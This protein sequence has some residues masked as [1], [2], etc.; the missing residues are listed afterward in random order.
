MAEE[1]TK[2]KEKKPEEDLKVLLAKLI[3]EIKAD[4]KTTESLFNSLK[5]EKK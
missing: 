4:L 3:E 1:T 2:K 5:G